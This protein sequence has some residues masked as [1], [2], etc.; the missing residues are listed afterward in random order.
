MFRPL[1][2]LL[3]GALCAAAA[4]FVTEPDAEHELAKAAADIGPRVLKM[5]RELQEFTESQTRSIASS[6]SGSWMA[7]HA[8]SMELVQAR[9]GMELCAFIGDSLVAW[10]GT[11]AMGW[12]RS[13]AARH[14]PRTDGSVFLHA[15]RVIGLLR[16]RAFRPV[17]V[18]PPVQNR[19]LIEGFH[20]AVHAPPGARAVSGEGVG[21]VISNDQGK[22]L[23]RLAWNEGALE[24]GTWLVWRL[25][26]LAMSAFFI[27]AALWRSCFRLVGQ[28]RVLIG[29]V[30]FC[31]TVLLLRW[32]TLAWGHTAPFDRWPLFDPAIYATSKFF[33]SLGDLLINALLFAFVA[34]FL[35]ACRHRIVSNGDARSVFLFGG[36]ILAL[37]VWITRLCIGLIND[38]SID[39]DLYHVQSI[40]AYGVIALCIIAILLGSWCLVA[41][42]LVPIALPEKAGRSQWVAIAGVLLISIVLHHWYGIVDTIM[43]LWPVPVIVLLAIG[44]RQTFTFLMGVVLIA[45][46]AAIGTHILTKYSHGR[47]QRERVV[48]AERLAAREDPVVEQLFREVAPEIRRDPAVYAMLTGTTVCGP[49]ELEVVVRQPYFSGYWER[50][51]IR[52]FGSG[53]RGDTRC[54]TD[55]DPPRS[56]NDPKDAFPVGVSDMP[57]LFIDEW[58]EGDV[59]YHGRVAIMPNDS[60]PPAQL[61]VE[62]QPRSSAPGFG[63]PELLLAGDDALALRAERYEQARYVNGL[64]MYSSARS[65]QPM[66]WS[67]A[68]DENGERWYSVNGYDYL[69]KAVGKN[70]IMVLGIPTHGLVDKATTFSYLFTF[71]G[72]LA[73]LA[74]GV[75]LILTRSIPSLGIG[76][77][78]RVALVLFAITGLVL[79]GIG[80]QQLLTRQF[81]QRS[82]TESLEKAHAVQQELMRQLGDEKLDRD[83]HAAYLQHLL[84]RLGNSFFTD[85]TVYTPD[86]RLLASSRPQMF[87]VGLLGDRMDPLAFARLAIE[88]ASS[89]V[90]EENIGGATFRTAYVP[91]LDRHGAL[92]AHIALPRFADQHLQEEERSELLVAVVNLFVLL[93]AISIM[94]AVFISKWTTRPLDILK[95][96]LAGVALQ[97]ANAP[98][99]YRG[100][101]EV[102]ELVSVY[103]QKVDELRESAEKL[104]RSEREHAWKEMARQVAHEIKN[105]LT[106]MKLGIQ[107]FQNTWDP[108]A[109]DARAR[110]DRFNTS[111]VEQIDALSRV[112]GDFSRFAQLSE[113]NAT[114]VD[115]NEVARSAVDL[116][117]GER[118]A[119]IRFTPALDPVM[120]MA[121]KEH[122]LR[123]FNN[124]LKNAL[125]SIPDGRN[126]KVEVV[127]RS[128]ENAAIAEVRDNGSG[129]PAEVRESIFEPNFT[130]KSS[131]MGLGLA[132]VKRMVE[133][134][135]GTVR[136]ETTEDRGTTF[137]VTLPLHP[138]ADTFA[139]VIPGLTLDRE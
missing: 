69:A 31:T 33:P 6:G 111:M 51:D 109:P 115:M 8:E 138:E 73:L 71:F 139:V 75:R 62:L 24:M 133:Q 5:D 13:M 90:H 74:L 119:N 97:G 37:S 22:E 2:L 80:S 23:F 68:L 96:S 50:Y 70:T 126:G 79:F 56:T 49:G 123:I 100:K 7:D 127:I 28:G 1:P 129:I 93:F 18:C 104:A 76:T 72:L 45:L 57:D 11:S 103:N 116:F 132:M 81:A 38:S 55:L 78:V 34:S 98:I 64:L 14:E 30:L 87:S 35:W 92:L 15:E 52:L 53:P 131:G 67:V 128:Q 88:G 26:L 84:G 110:L 124:L 122:L 66:H 4:L 106:P 83:T 9:T 59:F 121:D 29:V 60:L 36:V 105:P 135:H 19:Y 3:L 102:G 48:L 107:H 86:G 42:S 99:Q 41:A 108:D 95:R 89:F 47:E 82:A 25:L 17:W 46:L 43:F 20:P 63:F 85:I 54:A 10:S 21:P 117:A 113:A 120:V 39:L 114:V 125:Q 91:L 27:L 61:L 12:S 101:D 40:D 134:A 130:T 16:V 118:D 137:V 77:K 44:H 136:F 65:S 112:A 94:L 32:L 58:S